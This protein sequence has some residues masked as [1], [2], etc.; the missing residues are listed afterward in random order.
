MGTEI[1]RNLKQEEIDKLSNLS[2]TNTGDEP[3]FSGAGSE[4]VVPDPVTATGK[5]LKDDGS[6]DTPSGGSQDLITASTGLRDFGGISI[7]GGDNTK[8]D[9]G[10]IKGQ[11]IDNTTDPD[12]PTVTEINEVAQT[13]LTPLFLATDP[14]TY[15]GW[16]TSGLE[17][18]N[19]PFT[20]SERRS[21]LVLGVVVHSN[22]II[23]NTFNDLPIISLSV[24]QQLVDIVE[25]IGI[26]NGSGNI[27]SSNGANFMINKS[28]GEF[29]KMG[30][31]NT[32]NPLSPN[33][34]MLPSIT[35]ATFRYRNQ[36]SSEGSD[37]TDID[38]NTYDV[39]G[40][41]TAVPNNRW[42]V[43][44][45]TIFSSNIVRIQRGQNH[46]ANRNAAIRNINVDP[47]VT[48]PN[49]Q[50]NGLTRCYIVMQEG[51]ANLN[52][53][54]FIEAAKFQNAGGGGASGSVWSPPPLALGSGFT[55]GA[56]VAASAGAGAYINFSQ[57]AD[58]EF[59]IGI[60]LNNNGL[61]YDGS[62]ITLEIEWMKFGI[63]V[64]TVNWE[65]DYAFVNLGDDAYSTIDGTLVESADVTLLG[66]QVLTT[67]SFIPISG[68]AGDRILQ[69]T[70]R[71]NSIGAG[72]DTY[73]GEAEIY[74]LNTK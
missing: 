59:L 40:V 25:K 41:T 49:I 44:R 17:Q 34:K 37:I 12:N 13:L 67:T 27:F 56:T 52:N 14:V 21:I 6:W 16:G 65:I 74:G 4:G 71:R 43:Q 58:N 70:F 38:P 36:D 10:V 9:L 50:Q 33:I 5:Y 51:A 72:A 69:L 62:P 64:G 28:P 73:T 7:N 60:G 61:E 29:V 15:I 22:N 42:T 54:T 1:R 18:R 45:V 53:A 55:N 8:F 39:G 3:T 19:V 66:N 63:G 31:N 20:P 48:E 47:F 32:I 30:V 2:G 57:G 46:Y 11:I 68:T 23:I 26:F 35:G 24:A